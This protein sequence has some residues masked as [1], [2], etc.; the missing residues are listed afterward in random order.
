MS[1]SI[2]PKMDMPI[3]WQVVVTEMRSGAPWPVATVQFLEGG[4]CRLIGSATQAYAPLLSATK[5]AATTLA[6]QTMKQQLTE[7]LNPS[8]AQSLETAASPE[9]L[10]RDVPLAQLN[11]AAVH[12][13]TM[14]D[15][16]LPPNL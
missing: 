14:L 5:K 3:Q 8:P 7:E 6:L 1:T 2:T 11:E 16:T 13:S 15:V 9:N 10:R 4:A 12:L